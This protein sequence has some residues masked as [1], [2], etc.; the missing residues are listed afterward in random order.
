MTKIIEL[1]RM[2]EKDGEKGDVWTDDTVVIR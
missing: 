2:T 1:V